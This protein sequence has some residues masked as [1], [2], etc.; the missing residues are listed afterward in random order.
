MTKKGICELCGFGDDSYS[1]EENGTVMK[2]CKFCH[3][4]Y[5]ER[6]G[7]PPDSDKPVG[8]VTLTLDLDSA[9]DVDPTEIEE[10]L[11]MKVEPLSEEE[12]KKVLD[13]TKPKRRRTMAASEQ[14][15]TEISQQQDK[16]Q[17]TLKAEQTKKAAA[18]LKKRRHDIMEDV[19]PKIDDERI[20]ITSPEIPLSRDLRPKTNLDVAVDE[21][22]N[23]VK[24]M[25]AFKYVFNQ[26][27]YA[28]FLGLVVATV[29]TVLFIT[30]TWVNALIVLAGGIGAIGL[31]YFIMWYLASRLDVDKRAYLLRIRQQ[32]I[33]FKSMNSDCYRELKTKFTV[34]KSLSWLMNKLSVILPL[35]TIVGSVV[36][37]VIFSFLYYTWL[38]P[39]ILLGSIIAGVAVYWIV[40]LLA[41]LV[42]YKLDA[43]RNQQIQQQTLLDIL[44]TLK[45]K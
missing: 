33:L 12:L 21:Y 39:I 41:D 16:A 29:A 23:S 24:F 31:S 9:D 18:L 43:E 19:N 4:G 14:N 15:A 40:K 32:E 11:E 2:V 35:V 45:N 34:L 7:L 13:G 42:T 44:K 22:K 17:E 27:V 25:E 1:I 3:D 10:N 6:M 5:L 8:D 26:V 38:L 37:A 28:I 36:C 30:D 20:K